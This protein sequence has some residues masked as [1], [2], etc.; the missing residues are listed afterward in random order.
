MKYDKE[1]K[2]FN[3]YSKRTQASII[4]LVQHMLNDKRSGEYVKNNYLTYRHGVWV[5]KNKLT[6]MLSNN[7]NGKDNLQMRY[8]K[9]E[10]VATWVSS[11]LTIVLATI[12]LGV[13]LANV[14][15]MIR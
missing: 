8:Y 14:I 1:H 7:I 3:T 13:L 5:L 9:L 11:G 15:L 2:N 12:L 4:L 10:R 6:N